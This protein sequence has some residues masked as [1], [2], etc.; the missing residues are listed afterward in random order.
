MRR[1]SEMSTFWVGVAAQFYVQSDGN[2]L[3]EFGPRSTI[4]SYLMR[5]VWSAISRKLCGRRADDGQ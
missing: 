3:Y 2:L 4:G 1:Y 5:V